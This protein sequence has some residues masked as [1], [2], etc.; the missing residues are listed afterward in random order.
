MLGVVITFGGTG[1]FV[2]WALWMTWRFNKRAQ[3]WV[4]EIQGGKEKKR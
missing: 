1:L 2:V 4:D 3:G